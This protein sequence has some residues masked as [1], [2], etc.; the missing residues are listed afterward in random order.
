MDKGEG[1]GGQ[2]KEE[3][4]SRNAIA[5]QKSYGPMLDHNRHSH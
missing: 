2:D 1:C 4:S 5:A 3:H